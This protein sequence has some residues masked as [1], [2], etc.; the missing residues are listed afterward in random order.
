[1]YRTTTFANIGTD[2]QGL[3]STEDV[4]NAANLNY[5]VVKKSMYLQD[6]SGKLIEYPDKKFT[7]AE[8]TDKIFGVVSPKYEICQNREAF[9][10]IDYIGKEVAGFQY[11]R[12]GETSNGIVYIIA[13]I[14][15]VYLF[16]D[17]ITPYIIFQNSHD[18][19][20]S[21]KAT[22]CPLR[23][24]CQ[25]Q[26]NLS[27]RNSPNTVR[28]V[29][30]SKLDRN[31]LTARSIMKDVSGYMQTFT[32]TADI[33]ATTKLEYDDVFKLYNDVFGGS[34]LINMSERQK[35]NFE[36]NRSKFMACYNSDDNQ[37]FRGTAW[38]VINGAA[39]Y[40]THH[41]VSRKTTPDAMFV[42]T[43]LAT[44]ALSQIYNWIDQFIL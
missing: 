28:I 19:L 14:P 5:K 25:N 24:V 38:G 39:D 8:G 32:L 44:S 29:H 23:I 15:N 1:M 22:I 36:A 35:K 43:T 40:L 27:F 16:E 12:A 21:V 4:L 20:S 34:S 41:K 26:F 13:R 31:L 3:K 42:N 2:I 7:V 18:G 9:N 17:A 30:S 33:L 6:D 11:V 37:N 10:F